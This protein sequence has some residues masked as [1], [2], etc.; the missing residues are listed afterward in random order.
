MDRRLS[1][2]EECINNMSTGDNPFY[3]IGRYEGNEEDNL[4][5]FHLGIFFKKYI[6]RTIT[7]EWLTHVWGLGNVWLSRHK[8]VWTILGYMS[9]IRETDFLDSTYTKFPSWMKIIRHSTNM[10]ITSNIVTVYTDYE[11]YKEILSILNKK[12]LIET[13]EFLYKIKDYVQYVDMSTGE[14]YRYLKNMYIY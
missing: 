14:I 5:H 8:K 13:G 11:G 12:S 3:Y 2:I 9:K 10:P 1:Y 4:F 6:P 7:H